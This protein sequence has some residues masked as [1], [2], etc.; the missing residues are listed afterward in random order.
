MKMRKL[1][2]HFLLSFASLICSLLLLSSPAR[3][4]GPNIGHAVR[5]ASAGSK[6]ATVHARGKVY[7]SSTTLIKGNIVPGPR[8]TK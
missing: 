8:S 3:A 2:S 4:T 7:K 6:S 1:P 5:L